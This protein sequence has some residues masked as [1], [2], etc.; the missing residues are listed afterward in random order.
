MICLWNNFHQL[1]AKNDFTEPKEPLWFLKAPN[2]Y[3]PANRPIQRPATYAG[4]II[5]E[6]ELGVVIGKKCFNIRE[7]EAGD[8]I[9]G[10][11]CVNDVTAVDLLRKDPVVRTMG[12]RQEFRHVWR[13][14]PG[15]RH[16]RRS[17]EAIGQDRP[18]RQGKAE[19]SG[20]RHV[21]PA[22]PAGCRH[23]ERRD[24]DAGRRHRL[25][26][27]ARRRHHGRRP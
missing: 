22:A 15:H 24:A 19:L 12:A 16:R 25:R 23:I 18:E 3:W 13:L 8:Y 26:H 10:Y 11:T 27:L 2:A 20:R 4:K 7:A 14:R 5:Y 1:A 6:G 9:F 21:L 17:D